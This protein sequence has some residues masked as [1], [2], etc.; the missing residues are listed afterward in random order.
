ME[1]TKLSNNE[2]I[3]LLSRECD[4]RAA[5][6]EFVARFHKHIC[7]TI[8]RETKRRDYTEGFLH[9]EDLAQDVYRKLV[10]DNCKAL[11][12]FIGKYENSIFKYLEVI[13]IRVVLNKL[14]E[15]G[16]P[17][18]VKIPLDRA[19]INPN[20]DKEISLLDRIQTDPQIDMNELKEEIEYCLENIFNSKKTKE[21]Y[22]LV[23][24]YY[25]YEGFDSKLI[26]LSLNKKLSPKRI[27]NIISETKPDLQRCLKKRLKIN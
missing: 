13:S 10:K 7:S 4:N 5:W 23:I 6:N 8:Y 12:N 2:L 3:K 1:Y 21:I 15:K 18:K 16:I 22:K 27:S 11:K 14:N 19:F 25:I 9:V 17:A 20:T 24:K 26:S